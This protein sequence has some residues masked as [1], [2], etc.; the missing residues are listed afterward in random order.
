MPGMETAVAPTVSRADVRFPCGDTTCA[1]WLYTPAR[2]RDA[3]GPAVVMGHGLGAVKE[4][5]LDPYARRF[6]QAGYIVLV[7]DYRHFGESGGEPR[8]LLDPERQLEDFAAALAYVRDLPA[9]DADRV[10]VFGSSFGGGHAIVV[11]ARDPRVAAAIAQ[12]PFTFG[13]RSAMAIDPRGTV[14]VAARAA[15][16]IAAKLRG[17]PP[18]RVALAGD[19]GTPALMNTPD[20]REGYLQLVPPGLTVADGVAARVALQI[21][22]L[23]PGAQARDVQCPILF[24][25]CD[26]DTVAPPGPTLKYAA[27][28]PRGEIVRYPIGHFDIYVGEAFEQAVTDQLAFLQQHMPVPASGA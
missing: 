23:R 24:C 17:R 22:F 10:A 5:G 21:P 19:P 12:C 1:G 4:M 8:Q 28:A 16:D 25:V 3:P 7:F 15:R 2:V 13:P 26:K 18:V 6:A 14:G 11:A 9:V 27:R 20:A